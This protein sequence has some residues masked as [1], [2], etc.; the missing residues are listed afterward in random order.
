[1]PHLA[2]LYLALMLLLGAPLDACVDRTHGLPAWYDPGFLPETQA[3][4]D[5]LQTAA[6]ADGVAVVMFSGYRPYAYQ[7]EVHAREVA[8]NPESAELLSARA[9][10]SEHQLGTALDAAWPGVGLGVDDPRND[11]LY[12]WLEAH[13]HEFGFVLSYPLRTVDEWPYSNRWLP[14]VTE[15]VHEPWHLRYVGL[16][17]AQAL[18][19]EGYLDPHSTVLPQDHCEPWP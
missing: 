13:A 15:Y 7:E 5:E 10:H 19:A 17:A 18:Y 4:F 3:A 11:L 6:A 14:V 16:E 1:L 2:Q 8:L 12:P 9:G